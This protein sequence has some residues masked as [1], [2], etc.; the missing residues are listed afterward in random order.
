VTFATHTA[1]TNSP[2]MGSRRGRIHEA[3]HLR[4]I[5]TAIV[6]RD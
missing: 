5:F 2:A 4:K 1:S 3:A 6:A